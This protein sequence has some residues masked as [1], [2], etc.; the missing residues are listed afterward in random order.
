MKAFIVFKV[1]D[2]KAR[3]KEFIADKVYTHFSA[4]LRRE[5]RLHNQPKKCGNTYRSLRVSQH[6][7]KYGTDLS[8][9]VVKSAFQQTYIIKT[10]IRGKVNIDD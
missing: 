2:I 5:N 3:K 10:T 7:N 6:P 1:K 8:G 4:A 9:A